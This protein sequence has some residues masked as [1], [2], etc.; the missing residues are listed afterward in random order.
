MRK[1]PSLKDVATLAGVSVTTVSRH[2]NGFLP[3]PEATAGRIGD[4]VGRLGYQP[5]PHARRLS[6]GR[7]E[8]IGL[9][10]PDIGN[11]FFARLV[12]AIEAAAGEA[13][14]GVSLFA[15]LNRRSRELVYL[16]QLRRNHVDGLI[17]VTNHDDADAALARQ[18]DLAGTVVI[19]D[20]DV[21]DT[22]VPKLFCDNWRGG[23][24]A[25]RHF[26]EAGHTRLGYVGSGRE[27]ISTRRRCGG[28]ES[29]LAEA[30]PA[31]RLTAR[32]YGDYTVES[33]RRAAA[34]FVKA[35][36]PATGLFVASD[37]IA[38]GFLEV[39][40]ARGIRVPEDVSLIG[41]DDVGPL[42]LF[43]PP[44]TAVRQPVEQLGRRALEL[45]LQITR[46]TLDPGYEELLPVELV[47]RSS[48]APP[49]VSP[50]GRA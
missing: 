11:L 18:I 28:F 7:A 15:T 22:S 50:P 40:G 41:F 23:W 32:F 42:H 29:A 45:L 27:M 25:G 46:Q 33:G 10:V 31:C 48:V 38:V 16:D 6:L 35:G 49:R 39:L 44:L 36:L 24:L 20:E 5:N 9:V 8:T 12:A 30:D 14:L 21:S 34:E 4:A 43:S 13:G 3:L 47:V 19:V 17:F 2:L 1:L 26:V 37:E